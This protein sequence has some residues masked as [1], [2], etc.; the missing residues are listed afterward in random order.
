MHMPAPAL[1]GRHTAFLTHTLHTALT[2]LC[3]LLG[4]HIH[5]L[6]L[7]AAWAV[8]RSVC[9]QT[10]TKFRRRHSYP[11]F[12]CHLIDP[13]LTARSILQRIRVVNY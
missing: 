8:C 9:Y 4:G 3:I 5:S 1:E 11:I 2:V 13:A 6:T 12:S 10:V 7:A